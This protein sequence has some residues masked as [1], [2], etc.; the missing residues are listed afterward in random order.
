MSGSDAT[1]YKLGDEQRARVRDCLTKEKIF[2]APQCFDRLVRDI[3]ASIEHFQSAPAKGSF[4]ETHDALAT[5]WKRC[6]LDPPPVHVLRE[7]LKNFRS[8]P[9]NTWI[10]GRGR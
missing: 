9:L 8:Q 2:V 6:R 7:E 4:R 1:Q 10:V 3:E 5:L